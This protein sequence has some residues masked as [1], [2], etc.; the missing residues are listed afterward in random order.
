MNQI[1]V[2]PKFKTLAR[3][4]YA[5]RGVIY[6]VIGG[7]ALMTAFGEGGQTTDSRGAILKIL[8]QPFGNVLLVILILGLLG[9]SAWRFVQASRD[10]D[11]HGKDAKG[12]AVRVGLFVSAIT[13]LALAIWAATL[14]IGS[15]G[16]S[17]GGGG[18]SFLSTGWGQFLL[19]AA[20]VAVIGAGIAH[21]Y[22]GWAAKFEKYMYIP[23]DKS[24]WATPVCRFGLIARGVVWCIVGWFLID[25][26]MGARSGDVKGIADALASLRDSSFGPWLL[27]IVAAG[28]VAFGIYSELEALY[29][30]I[31][32]RSATT[33][34]R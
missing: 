19:G 26:V 1:A 14:L 5:A 25:S 32:T 9:Y 6:L 2:E 15:G 33:F 24:S 23:P 10:T 18:Q 20:G 27:G 28:L 11:G 21:I 29:R 30:R 4:G 31:N 17:S 12:L 34:G 3:L 13:H 7:L 16:S 8:E 22:K